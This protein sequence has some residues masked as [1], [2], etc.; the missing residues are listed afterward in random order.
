MREKT[1]L[2]G[3]LFSGAYCLAGM[4]Y[5]IAK[6]LQAKWGFH[7]AELTYFNFVIVSVCTLPRVMRQGGIKALKTDRYPLLLFRANAGSAGNRLVS[8]TVKIKSLRI[9]HDM[10]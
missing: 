5:G 1:M 7:P 9:P 3:V 10:H 6:Y 4:V 8:S 2:G